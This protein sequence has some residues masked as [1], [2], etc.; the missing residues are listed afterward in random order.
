MIDIIE[1]RRKKAKKTTYVLLLRKNYRER[2]Y[3]NQT[4]NI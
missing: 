1:D 2:Q 3:G 4:D